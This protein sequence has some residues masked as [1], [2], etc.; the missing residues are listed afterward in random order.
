MTKFESIE[1]IYLVGKHPKYK[2]LSY[3]GCEIFTLG[4][5]SSSPWTKRSSKAKVVDEPA[6]ESNYDMILRE[7]AT[8]KNLPIILPI[9]LTDNSEKE[10]QEVWGFERIA[11]RSK[12]VSFNFSSGSTGPAKIQIYKNQVPIRPVDNDQVKVT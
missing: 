11:N 1:V 9:K 6:A 5:S 10:K 4:L 8:G 12:W 7:K 3:S 2:V